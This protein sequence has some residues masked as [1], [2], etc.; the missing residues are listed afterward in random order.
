MKLYEFTDDCYI[1]QAQGASAIKK[2]EVNYIKNGAHMVERFDTG[3][4]A[5]EFFESVTD[6]SDC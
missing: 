5:V 6:A 3:K 4:D 1:E 2:W